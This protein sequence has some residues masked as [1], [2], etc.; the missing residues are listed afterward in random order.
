MKLPGMQVGAIPVQRP[1]RVPC[2]CDSRSHVITPSCCYHDNN[3]DVGPVSSKSTSLREQ[4]M[5]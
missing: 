1:A 5:V 4:L 2:S 3:I